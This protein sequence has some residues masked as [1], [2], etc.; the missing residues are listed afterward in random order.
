MTLL[1]PSRR[2]LLRA[3]LGLVAAPA[4][5]RADSLMKVVAPRIVPGQHY[6]LH[7]MVDDGDYG[8]SCDGDL[9]KLHNWYANFGQQTVGDSYDG[10]AWDFRISPA[11]MAYAMDAY[12]RPIT[13]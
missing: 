2:G 10:M 13:P 9:A 5:V 12:Y 6:L 8:V 1:V 11:E 4:I 7:W 3:A